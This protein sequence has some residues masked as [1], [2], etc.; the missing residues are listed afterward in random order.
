[1]AEKRTATERSRAPVLDRTGPEPLYRQ[2]AQH[3][4]EA[5]RSGEL[6]PGDRLPSEDVL[7]RR[8]KVSR[9]TLRQAVD[10]LVR[11]E[12]IVRRQGKGTFVSRPAVKHDLKRLHGL[13]AS[14]FGQAETAS[15]KLLRYELHRAPPEIAE[16]L[17]LR[18]GQRALALDRLYLIGRRPV[19]YAQ[20]W[21]VPE[22]AALPR[23]KADLISTE[24]MMR[25]AGI[26][27]VS[28]QVSIRAETAGAI[29]GRHL[30]LTA[31]APVLVLRRRA[32]GDDGNVKEA[33]R[34]WF[35]SDAYEFC[36]TDDVGR[37]D[38]LFDIRS[39]EENA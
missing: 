23:A 8:Y 21:L 1:M 27:I 3:L 33:G 5:I 14:L 2:I 36:A 7:T 34:L 12:I 28:T 19:A 18:E 11:K 37:A 31:R 26:H 35:C 4:E 38:H 22:V 10:A 25:D 9:I 24:D 16:L 6:K 29:A 30:K 39:V 17:G 32:V 13:L 15:T 20:N